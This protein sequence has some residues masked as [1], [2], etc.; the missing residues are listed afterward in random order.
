M[1][2]VS[3]IRNRKNEH[4]TICL[5]KNVESN[6]SAGFNNISIIHQALPELDF[7]QIDTRTTFLGK[8][9]N[10]PLLISSMTGGSKES[11][12]YNIIFAEIANHFQIAMGVGS[13]R[14]AIEDSNLEDTFKVRKVAPNILLFANIGA[15]QLN[16]GYGV[17]EVIKAI[18]MIEAD[19][20]FLHLNP[21]Q[22][23]LQA[24]GNTNFTG[25]LRK[26]ERICKSIETPV[27]IKEV[28]CGINAQTARLLFD[29][30]VRGIDCAGLGGTSWALVE[31]ERH[32]DQSMAT[33]AREFGNWGIPTVS[34]LLDYRKYNFSKHIIASG[35][36]RTGM[37]I[38]KSIALGAH[39]AGMALP[40]LKAASQGVEALNVFIEN[41]I[42]ELIITMFNAKTA[43]IADID[44]STIHIEE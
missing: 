8:S 24:E 13:Q 4:L 40:F 15:V 28:G 38:F 17:A 5:E 6:V 36:I 14:A 1:E 29:S 43:T 31:A 44:I 2:K 42:E 34:C 26:I 41:I 23:A 12:R 9:L 30:G 19:A 16:Y 25:L 35:G 20:V 22:E 37:D 21:L 7:N 27:F 3:K 39:L 18:D 33:L 32:S 10:A 11:A